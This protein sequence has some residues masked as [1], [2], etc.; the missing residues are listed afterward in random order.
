MS[1]LKT[2]G[3][4]RRGVY[5]GR[6]AILKNSILVMVRGELYR[7]FIAPVVEIGSWLE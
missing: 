4:L 2:N 7:V 1:E 5:I 3:S 6:I